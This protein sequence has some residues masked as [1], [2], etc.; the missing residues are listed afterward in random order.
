MRRVVE[1]RWGY[2]LTVENIDGNCEVLTF[3][4]E[5]TCEDMFHFGKPKEIEW[6]EELTIPPAKKLV[7]ALSEVV[8][9]AEQAKEVP[10]G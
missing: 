1:A 9:A 4:G 5:T 8:E 3:S 7:A 6:W 2:N 10:N